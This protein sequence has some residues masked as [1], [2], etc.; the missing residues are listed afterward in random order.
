MFEHTQLLYQQRPGILGTRG[1]GIAE[2]RVVSLIIPIDTF[3]VRVGLNRI[4]RPIGEVISEQTDFPAP[5]GLRTLVAF[6]SEA[7][8]LH[9]LRRLMPHE[10]QHIS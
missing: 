9:S 3:F 10:A 1:S 2:P 4:V 8:L 6:S 7:N 5:Q